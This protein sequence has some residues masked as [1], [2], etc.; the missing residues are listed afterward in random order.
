VAGQSGWRKSLASK[1]A[2][3]A[4][5]VACVEVGAPKDFSTAKA[6]ATRAIMLLG[7]FWQQPPGITEVTFFPVRLW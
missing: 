7:T 3:A 4:K 5:V 1:T 2:E 6:R